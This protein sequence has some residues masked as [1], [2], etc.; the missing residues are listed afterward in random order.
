LDL[1][2]WGYVLATFVSI[3]ITFMGVT[4][5]LHRD[6]THRSLDLHPA[7]RH[8]F[9]FWLWF[10]SGTL[11]RQWVAVHRRHHSVADRIG[12]PH[13]PVIFGLKRV[14][15]EGYELYRAAARDPALVE[16]YGRGT[17]DDWL[18]R[19]IYGRRAWLGITLFVTTELVLFGVPAIVMV[20]AH[21]VSQPLFAGGIINGVGHRIGYRSFEVNAAATNIVPWGLIIAGEELH[22]NHHAFPRSARFS[23]QPWEIDIGWWFICLFRVL[24][25]AH[26]RR[27]APQPRIE[28]SRQVLDADT[29]HA[30][31]VNRM[32]VLRDYARSVI[33]PVCADL[34]AQGSLPASARRLLVRHPQLLGAEAR[35]RLSS[36]LEQ[37]E[38]LRAVVEFRDRLQLLWT[39]APM[40]AGALAGLKQWC[41]QAESSGVRALHEFALSLRTYAA[42]NSESR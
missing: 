24:G 2:F 30:L 20:A 38:A 33:R 7:L 1:S 25:L 18:E 12:D 16:N 8:F 34:A 13:S 39:G 36:L 28:R 11:T 26:V 32:H 17:P 37:H 42:H 19:H 15:L 35:A 40:P 10:S 3:Q 5:F 22:N 4:L 41:A 23:V 29:A 9:R 31:F 27:T 14:V 21:L 6:A